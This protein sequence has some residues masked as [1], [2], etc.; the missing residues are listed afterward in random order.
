[1]N[2]NSLSTKSEM[3]IC[4]VTRYLIS[5]PNVSSHEGME[6]GGRAGGRG[7][8]GDGHVGGKGEWSSHWAFP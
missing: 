6:I 4:S 1:M 2:K 3:T 7:A 5:F 8:N